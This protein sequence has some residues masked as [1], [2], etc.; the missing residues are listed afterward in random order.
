MID[1]DNNMNKK[2]PLREHVSYNITRYPDRFKTKSISAP[3][4]FNYPNIHLEVNTEEDFEFIKNG[5]H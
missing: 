5:R 2:D 4:E 3:P 1:I